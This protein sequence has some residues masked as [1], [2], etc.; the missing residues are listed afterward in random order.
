MTCP[1]AAF[2]SQSQMAL[3]GNIG[4]KLDGAADIAALYGED[5]A[6]YVLSVPAADA[7]AI[8]E[9]AKKAGHC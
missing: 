8:G 4:V 6:R 5:Q 7:D 9:A 2:S 3:G 1:T